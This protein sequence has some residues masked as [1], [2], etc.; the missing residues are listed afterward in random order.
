MSQV[1]YRLRYAARLCHD[2]Y[3]SQVFR[4]DIYL[5]QKGTIHAPRPFFNLFLIF[6][7]LF[8]SKQNFNLLL[9]VKCRYGLRVH[10][11][12]FLFLVSMSFSCCVTGI[13]VEIA[14]FPPVFIQFTVRAVRSLLSVYIFISFL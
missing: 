6:L 11:L 4:V 3:Y 2:L 10:S 9:T 7:S 1:P 12:K 14:G 8:F 5:K 13:L